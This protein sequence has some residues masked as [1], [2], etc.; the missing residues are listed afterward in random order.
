MV[1]LCD[2]YPDQIDGAKTQ[3]P[4]L[5]SA[6]VFKDAAELLAMPGLD[7]VF[8]CTPVYLHPE[9]FSLAVA[10]E[11]IIHSGQ[12]GEIVLMRPESISPT[13]PIDTRTT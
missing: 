3:T 9:Y 12:L 7:A 2:L 8:I 11:R 10:A 1:A 4:A 13:S 5:S 6:R